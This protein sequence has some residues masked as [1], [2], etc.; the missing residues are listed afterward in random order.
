VP[1]RSDARYRHHIALGVFALSS[2]LSGCGSNGKTHVGAASS[3]AVSWSRLVSLVRT[4]QATRVEQSHA[5]LVTV[6]VRGGRKT[7]AREPRIDAIVTVV[8]RANVHCGPIT[9]ATE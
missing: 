1:L 4:C 5:R 6:T 3:S 2:V 7:W 8:N 9:F